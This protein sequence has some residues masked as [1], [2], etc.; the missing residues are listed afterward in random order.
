MTARLDDLFIEEF[1]LHTEDPKHAAQAPA[2]I[3]AACRR[4]AHMIGLTE[5]RKQPVLTEMKATAKR[6]GYDW[7]TAPYDRHRNV[8]ILVRKALDVIHHD[9]VVVNNNYVV[10]VTIDFHGSKVT[11]HQSHI[12]RTD[13]EAD[14]VQAQAMVA[15]VR[16]SSKGSGLSV[17]G[18]DGNPSKPQRDPASEP[19]KTLR[20]ARMPS[21]FETLGRWPAGLG[22]TSLGHNLADTRLEV[23]KA[24]LHDA[25]GS[26]HRPLF[27]HFTVRR[28]KSAA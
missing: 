1:P 3:A 7:L 20:E 12:E 13:N 22:V 4:G 2:Q 11:M 19:N 10:S 21:V 27:A 26:D 24:E 5:T 16:A 14:Q 8:A 23:V 18:F 15:A 28:L 6:L 9:A 25:M 17:Y